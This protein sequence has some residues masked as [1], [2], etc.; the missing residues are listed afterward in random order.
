MYIVYRIPGGPKKRT[1]ERL[2]FD[3]KFYETV[4]NTCYIKC[5]KL[6]N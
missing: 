6:E 4:E 2:V 1:I 5:A 3:W